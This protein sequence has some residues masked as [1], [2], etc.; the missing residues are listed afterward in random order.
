MGHQVALFHFGLDGVYVRGELLGESVFVERGQFGALLTLPATQD[1]FPLVL[2]D[3]DDE[4]LFSRARWNEETGAVMNA[5]ISI[6]QVAVAVESAA[7]IK[8]DSDAGRAAGT[9]AL[10][11][12]LEVALE[13][14][15]GLVAWLRTLAGQVWL[16]PS[17]E[18][19]HLVGTADLLDVEHG[20][21]GQRA[22]IPNVG[23]P[24]RL[25]LVIPADEEAVDPTN[26]AEIFTA[27]EERRGPSTADLL[28]AD[29]LGTIRPPSIE[30]D[31]RGDRRDHSRAVLLAAIACEVKVR[32]IL[33]KKTPDD[34]RAL[35][36]VIIKNPFDVTIAAAELTHKTMKAAVGRSLHEDNHA[37]FEDVKK[38]FTIRNR[39][40]HSGLR[41]SVEQAETGVR[42]AQALFE[43]LAQLPE[44]R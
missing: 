39:V 24:Q 16:V 38:L 13:V 1:S 11:Q 18:L 30:V 9:T 15:Q 35:V 42:T 25:K 43:W 7:S 14:V 40:A 32:D 33:R 23:L 2:H 27:L 37:L 3:P 44:P 22:R 20:D 29:A 17:H 28:L 19:P 41:P 8:D 6:V 31:W 5:S 34:R 26:L 21:L 12:A 10:E 36:E 4:P